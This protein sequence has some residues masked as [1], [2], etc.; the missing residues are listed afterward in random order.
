MKAAP[1]ETLFVKKSFYT[2]FLPSLL[3]CLGLALGGLADCIFVGNTVGPVGLSAISIGILCDDVYTYNAGMEYYKYMEDRG[4]AESLHNLVW[5]LFDDE[6]GP[7]PLRII[8]INDTQ[9]LLKE[10]V[11]TSGEATSSEEKDIVC[12]YPCAWRSQLLSTGVR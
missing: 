5:I 1:R 3:S 12:S 2:F 11:N 10:A 8:D 4:Y 6:R 7:F 9:A